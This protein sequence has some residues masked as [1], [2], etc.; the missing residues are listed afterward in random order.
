MA[1]TKAAS[2][3]EINPKKAYRKSIAVAIENVLQE[4]KEKLG[5]EEFMHRLKKATKVLAH[6]LT[7]E[8]AAPQKTVAIKT[9]KAAKPVKKSSV[10]KKAR[11]KK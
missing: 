5:E 6:G 9:S 2:T 7:H 4:L 10:I 3:P 1:K 11:S 8:N